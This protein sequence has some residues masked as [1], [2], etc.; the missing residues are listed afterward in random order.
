MRTQIDV[1]RRKPFKLLSKFEQAQT[2]CKS[3]LDGITWLPNEKKYETCRDSRC[4]S[5]KA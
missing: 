1:G 3:V 2:G 4:F 5:T